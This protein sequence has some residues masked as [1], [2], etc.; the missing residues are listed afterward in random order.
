VVVDAPGRDE[1]HHSVGGRYGFQVRD[2]TDCLSGK[3][4]NR[5]QI[6]FESHFDVSGRA[7]TRINIDASFNTVV[8]YARI[9]T[10]S[11]DEADTC[12]DCFVCL[13]DG[14]HRACT[15]QHLRKFIG[16]HP[17]GIGCG[18]RPKSYL[19]TGEPPIQQGLTN[20]HCSSSLIDYDYREDPQP[21][22]LY[23]GLVCHLFQ[24]S[25]LS[26]QILMCCHS[27]ISSQRSDFLRSDHPFG[28][29]FRPLWLSPSR[30]SSN[31]LP[32]IQQG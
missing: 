20:R 7:D 1:M 11:Y 14:Q 3:K 12:T 31:S 13:A 16:Q 30:N 9:K 29:N 22:N 23:K 21:S 32:R 18:R 5:G 6:A 27:S 28:T 10:R 19:S 26:S 4:L 2:P 8:H 15:E 24:I 25:T 17:D